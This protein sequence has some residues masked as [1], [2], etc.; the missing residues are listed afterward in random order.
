MP[1]LPE[2]ETIRRQLAPQLEGRTIAAI[3]ILDARWTR[4]VP[5][6]LVEQRLL[7]ARVKRVG[8]AGKYLIWSLSD[9]QYLL[10]HL[11]MT[12]SLLFD[13]VADPPHTPSRLQLDDSVPL[14]YAAPPPFA[15]GPLAP[16]A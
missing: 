5:P 4:P 6:Q 3:E 10:M 8:R 15:S 14:A 9:D 13:P 2:V 1:E 12:G 16:P 11:R 7:G